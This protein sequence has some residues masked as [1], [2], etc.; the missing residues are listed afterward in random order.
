MKVLVRATFERAPR[1]SK[2]PAKMISGEYAE[3]PDAI[4]LG[5]LAK[6]GREDARIAG[7][8]EAVEI[9]DKAIDKAMAAGVIDMMD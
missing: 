2:E 6:C 1:G 3:V 8:D 7:D 9:I 5:Q 4:V